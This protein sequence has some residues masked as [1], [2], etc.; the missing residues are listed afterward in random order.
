MKLS[1][2]PTLLK[3]AFSDWMEDRAPMLG[4]ALAYYTIFSLGPLLVVVISIAGFV[5]G[6]A[7]A[8]GQIFTSIRDVLG[9]D[10][11][12]T[13]EGMIASASEPGAGITATVIGI[14]TLILGAIGIFGQLKTALNIVWEVPQKKGGGIFGFVRQNLLSFGMVLA[15]AFLLLVSLVVNAVLSTL[16]RFISNTLPGGPLLWQGVNYVVGLGIITLLFALI[17][18][19]LPDVSIPWKDVWLGAFVTAI[20]FVLGQIGLGIYLS[21]ANVGSAFGAAGS[22][23]VI[24]V[25]IYY[26]AQL[27]FLGAEITQVYSQSHGSR[28]GKGLAG[29]AAGRK[30]HAPAPGYAPP[31]DSTQQTPRR[32]PWFAH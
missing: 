32:S 15:C 10:G 17:F 27:V 11:A 30:S 21:L 28:R 12:R 13:V 22:L 29:G 14:V 2:L 25:W 9:D 31:E 23:V 26:S 1:Q 4:A 7:A 6:D 24:L 3:E 5:L 8:S 16:G 19:F 20:L 18:K